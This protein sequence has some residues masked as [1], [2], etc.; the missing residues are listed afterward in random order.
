[1]KAE[2]RKRERKEGREGGRMIPITIY[3]NS[4]FGS[5]KGTFQGPA[6]PLETSVAVVGAVIVTPSSKS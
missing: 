3:P 1:M 4:L 2:S 6:S 5:N